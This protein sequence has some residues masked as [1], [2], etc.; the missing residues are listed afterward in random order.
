MRRIRGAPWGGE[1]RLMDA[2]GKYSEMKKFIKP[3]QFRHL[4]LSCP[5]AKVGLEA[6]QELK[7]NGLMMLR[8]NLSKVV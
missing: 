5:P 4:R 6:D 7:E 1:K 3:K 8:K 2:V